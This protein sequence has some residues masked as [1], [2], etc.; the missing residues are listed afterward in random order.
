MPARLQWHIP[1]GRWCARVH[2]S[3]CAV[4]RVPWDGVPDVS[5]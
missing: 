2:V 5:A 4:C 3:V 1:K